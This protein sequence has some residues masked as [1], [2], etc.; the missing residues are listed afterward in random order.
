MNGRSDPIR[1]APCSGGSVRASFESLNRNP[2]FRQLFAL[3]EAGDACAVSDLFKEFDYVV[4]G[5]EEGPG[6]DVD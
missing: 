3:A 1:R 6:H 2:R 4:Q 5:C